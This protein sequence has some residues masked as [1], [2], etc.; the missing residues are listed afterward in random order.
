VHDGAVL[1]S[2]SRVDPLAIP[3][4]FSGL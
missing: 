2:V 4:P 3:D 1:R